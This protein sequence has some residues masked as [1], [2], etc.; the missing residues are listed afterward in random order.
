MAMRAFAWKFD[1]DQTLNQMVSQLNAVGPWQWEA[2]ES[3]WYC[4]YLNCRPAPG[5]RVR[6]H[7]HGEPTPQH[8]FERSAP[9]YTMQVDIDTELAGEAS[10]FVSLAKEL[11]AKIGALNIS[12]IEAY[13]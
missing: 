8:N 13:D 4:D 3:Y 10:G 2:R 11:L 5:V 1:S 6:I 7:D 12:E 9:D